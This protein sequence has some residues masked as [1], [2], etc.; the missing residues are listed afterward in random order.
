MKKKTK[1]E[2]KQIVEVHI[3]IH[4]I[5]QYIQQPSFPQPPYTPNYPTQPNTTPIYPIVTCQSI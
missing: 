2:T 3:Y 4:Q 5:P 1:K